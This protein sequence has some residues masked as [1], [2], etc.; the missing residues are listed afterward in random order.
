MSSASPC[1]RY[2]GG[3]FVSNYVWEHGVGPRDDRPTTLDL[4]WRSLETNQVGTDEFLQWCERLGV[5]PMLA[6]NLG[7]RGLVEA[8]ELL[9]YCNAEAGTSS[10]TG[11]SR[12][13]GS[14]RTRCDLWCLGN[15]MDGPWQI[16]HKTADEYARLA[17]ETGGP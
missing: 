3:N 5:R 15:E 4:A 1:V 9:Q 7:T 14:S 10:P 11:G 17:E 13:A 6:V 8:V 12:T 2:P 16:G